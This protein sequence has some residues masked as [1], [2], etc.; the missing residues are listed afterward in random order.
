MTSPRRRPA[1]HTPI[2]EHCFSDTSQRVGVA[3]TDLMGI[4]HHANYVEYFERGRLEYMRRRG[5][6]YKQMVDRGLHMPVV[7][8]DIRYRKPAHF[9]DLLCVRTRLGALSRVTVRFDYSVTRVEPAAGPPEQLIEGHVL[10]ACIDTRHR[11]RGLPEDLV[12]V[13]FAQEVTTTGR[14]PLAD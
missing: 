4:V 12:E 11:P 8:L 1:L 14:L 10:L 2:P 7:E 5:L 3:D 13:L 9:D 6:S